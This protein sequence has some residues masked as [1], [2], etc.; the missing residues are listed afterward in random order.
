M[1]A[2]RKTNRRDF[3]KGKSAAEI[4]GDLAAGTGPDQELPPSVQATSEAG[5]STGRS[6]L[7][8]VGRRAMACQFQVFLNAGQHEQAV[9]AATEALDRVDLLETQLSVYLESSDISRINRLAAEQPCN[10]QDGA[11]RLLERCLSLAEETDGAFDITAAPLVKLWGFFVRQGRLPSESDIRDTLRLVGRSHVRLD[12]ERHSISLAKPGVA[13]NLGSIGK[14][15]ALDQCAHT[16]DSAGVENYLI[17]GGQSSIRARGARSQDTQ[18]GCWSVALVH[19]LRPEKRLA[20]IELVDRCLGT[21]GCSRQFFYHRGHRYGHILDPRTG[22]PAEGVLSATVLAPRAEQADALATA[23]F[24]LGV[25]ASRAY[26]EHH[27]E[28]SAL[29]VLAGHRQGSVTL[30]TIAMDDVLGRL[31]LPSE[32]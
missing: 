10:V 22:R 25:E 8:Q 4:L 9:E 6:Y 1:N 31:D 5:H 11:F 26:C 3:L 27:P 21:S 2:S 16:L 28:L 20:E 18:S 30:E 7:L 32:G 13:L 23:F 19:P 17:H 15:Y 14:G 24:V 12:S 29:F